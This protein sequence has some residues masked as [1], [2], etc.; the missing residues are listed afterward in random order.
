MKRTLLILGFLA[1]A[2]LACQA[3]ALT[4]A[5]HASAASAA[6]PT[7]AP[8]T[9]GNTTDEAPPPVL[10]FTIGI[11]IEPLGET[12]QGYKG[13]KG[14]Y[15]AP[16]LLQ[17]HANDMDLLAS[18]VES[19]GGVMTIQTQSPFTTAAIANNNTILADLAARGHEIGLH[20]HEDAHLGK[21]PERLRGEEWCAI[22]QEEI[23]YIQQASGVERVRYWSGGNLYPDL[24]LAASC[25][26]LD[27]NSDWKN[28][29]TQSTPLELV[30]VNPWRP[31]GGTDGEDLTAFTT[32]DPNGP[33][34][35]L[36][37]GQY[38]QENFASMRRSQESGGDQAYFDYLAESLYASLE[39][40]QPGMVNV[41]H[42]TVHPGEF[43]GDPARPFEVIDKFLTEVVDPLVAEGRVQWAT[44]S[45]MADLYI[46]WEAQQT[47]P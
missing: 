17:K 43:R 33:V 20:F 23:G 42:F 2:L 8:V 36:P 24:F 37:E 19:H 9:E 35:F 38:D 30:G 3:A 29:K 4:P 27:V 14:N 7:H 40:A 10:L 5:Q 16:G 13:G 34:I 39:A 28:P 22:M 32:H 1:L 15:N 11:H 31:S 25:A 46:Q 41:F 26:G 21:N 12:A 44:Y 45:Q 47:T 18:I 6:T